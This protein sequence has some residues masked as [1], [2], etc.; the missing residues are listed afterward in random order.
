MSVV[1]V[2]QGVITL[3]YSISA[4]EAQK[5]REAWSVHAEKVRAGESSVAILGNG[6]RFT[7]YNTEMRIRAICTYCMTPNLNSAAWCEGC[8]APMGMICE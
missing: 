3:P 6:A 4:N 5:L 2:L 7:P 8:G 1:N